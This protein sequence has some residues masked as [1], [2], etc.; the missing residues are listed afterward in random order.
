MYVLLYLRCFRV[1][2]F[3]LGFETKNCQPN[4]VTPNFWQSSSSHKHLHG[5]KPNPRL[6]AA[7]LDTFRHRLS[8]CN[9]GGGIW[10][11][12]SNTASSCHP[13]IIMSIYDSDLSSY[14]CLSLI[15]LIS[16]QTV[17]GQKSRR[18]LSSS[19][20]LNWFNICIFRSPPN[21]PCAEWNGMVVICP[22][23]RSP[24]RAIWTIRWPTVKLP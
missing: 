5:T 4:K 14:L 11:S 10:G 15:S 16:F 20:S 21:S 18:L 13:M 8:P 1:L 2:K 24:L 7:D 19:Q 3:W 22:P 17:C 9:Y 6:K 23:R 12:F